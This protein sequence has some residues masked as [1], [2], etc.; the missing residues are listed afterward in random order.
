MEINH[1]SKEDARWILD[2]WL[3]EKNHSYLSPERI[4]MHAK[5]QSIVRG[6]KVDNPSCACEH[7][8]FQKISLSLWTQFE[9]QIREIAG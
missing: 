1:I 9:T 7:Q 8:T 4:Q 6:K 5:M 3:P 2:V